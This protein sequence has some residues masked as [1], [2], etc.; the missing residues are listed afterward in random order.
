MEPPGGAPLPSSAI[1][2]R[3]RAGRPVPSPRHRARPPV[4]AVPRAMRQCQTAAAVAVGLCLLA[5]GQAGPTTRTSTS[6]STRRPAEP[7]ASTVRETGAVEAPHGSTCEHDR[8]A[9]TTRGPGRPLAGRPASCP[10]AD[11]VCDPGLHKRRGSRERLRR[12][13]PCADVVER[14]PDS[15]GTR[16]GLLWRKRRTAVAVEACVRTRRER[17]P[18]RQSSNAARA[19]NA[20][21]TCAR[22]GRRRRFQAVFP[23]Q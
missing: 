18:R 9:T 13:R 19:G 16:P 10:N 22:T 12:G 4:C 5:S 23:R 1:V 8:T 11:C 3:A 14:R 17:V 2:P 6:T 21:P 20:G 7:I 15:A